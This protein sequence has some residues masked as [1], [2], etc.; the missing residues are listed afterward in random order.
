MVNFQ[1]VYEN[2]LIQFGW[3]FKA[4]RKSNHM[5]GKLEIDF[6]INWN[7]NSVRGEDIKITKK[8]LLKTY[9]V[10]ICINLFKIFFLDQDTLH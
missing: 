1:R 9:I 7:E 8:C 10:H 2:R 5:K 4:T 3:R 6:Y